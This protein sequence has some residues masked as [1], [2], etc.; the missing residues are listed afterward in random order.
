[1]SY[2]LENVIVSIIAIAMV[3]GALQTSFIN[4]M[5]IETVTDMTMQIHPDVAG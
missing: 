3:T 1:M 4:M 2:V 5:M